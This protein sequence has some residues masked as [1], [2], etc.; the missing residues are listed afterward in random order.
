MSEAL[1]T[2]YL[3]LGDGVGFNVSKYTLARNYRYM[4]IYE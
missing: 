3:I 4:A 2:D 1:T